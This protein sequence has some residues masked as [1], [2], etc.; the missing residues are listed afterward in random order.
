MAKRFD[1][2]NSVTQAPA[3]VKLILMGAFTPGDSG[4]PSAAHSLDTM[5]GAEHDRLQLVHTHL[6]FDDLAISAANTSI[7]WSKNT[8]VTLSHGGK[9][10]T[11]TPTD[12]MTLTTSNVMFLDGSV[13]VVDDDAVGTFLEVSAKVLSGSTHNDCFLGLGGDD[14][15][16][17][18]DCNDCI[19]PGYRSKALVNDTINSVSG[20][21]IL[22]YVNGLSTTPHVTVNL[23]NHTAVSL[24]GSFNINSIEK[25]Y[26]TAQNDTFIGG[27]P[28]HMIDSLGNFTTEF[29]ADMAAMMLSLAQQERFTAPKLIT[30][31]I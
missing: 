12:R 20:V 18:G 31:A 22:A 21:N 7:S 23:A 3:I 17:A 27:D 16:N 9:T 6:L 2:Q 14:V 13:L 8:S 28:T 25:V 15:I 29:F 10:I 11:F 5:S 30:P 4:S 26:G 19:A 1:L 24:Q